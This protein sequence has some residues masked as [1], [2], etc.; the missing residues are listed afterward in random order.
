MDSLALLLKKNSPEPQAWR[1]RYFAY[2]PPRRDEAFIRALVDGL[3]RTVDLG[4]R[5][6]VLDFGCGTG[7]QTVEIARRGCRV[8][9]V[10]TDAP[11]LNEA[12]NSADNAMRSN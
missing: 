10:D 2:L 9:G 12:R 6:R 3:G 4:D 5:A 11:R 8:L 1:E 7:R